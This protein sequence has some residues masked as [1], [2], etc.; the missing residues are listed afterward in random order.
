[1]TTFKVAFTGTSVETHEFESV[2]EAK[3]FVESHVTLSRGW[4][5]E[6]SFNRHSGLHTLTLFNRN[7]VPQP[8]KSVFVRRVSPNKPRTSKSVEVAPVV[9]TEPKPKRVLRRHHTTA[10]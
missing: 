8:G 10:A 2:S 6:W 7:N 5:G 3:S 1:M 9:E 4:H